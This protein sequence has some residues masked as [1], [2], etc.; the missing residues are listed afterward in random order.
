MSS[1]K[2]WKTK[3]SKT[4]KF[5]LMLVL[6]TSWIFSGWP[7]IWQNPRIFLG[8]ERAL[9]ATIY[10]RT[11]NRTSITSGLSFTVSMDEYIGVG[12]DSGCNLGTATKTYYQ[13][14][15]YWGLAFLNKD[16]SDFIAISDELVPASTLSHTFI[17]N[18][19]AKT[20]IGEV[21][22]ICAETPAISFN[23]WYL[24]QYTGNDLEILDAANPITVTNISISST[25]Q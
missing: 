6:I 19:P 12:Y 13:G 9:A 3:L 8:A 20:E 5:L 17:K 25:S 14:T 18:F 15:P 11:P 22:F 24:T 1:A 7:P 21:I 23:D 4:P 2:L 16:R 10:Q